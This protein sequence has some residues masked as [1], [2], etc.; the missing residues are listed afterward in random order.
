MSRG[1]ETPNLLNNSHSRLW[2]TENN[3][4]H[5]ERNQSVQLTKSAHAEKGVKSFST[6]RASML[7]LLQGQNKMHPAG[8]QQRV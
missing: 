6:L 7:E 2:K 8:W 3:N 1:L 5:R 4:G